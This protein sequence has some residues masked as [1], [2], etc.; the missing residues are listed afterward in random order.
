M[1]DIINVK[2]DFNAVGDGVVDDYPAVQAALNAA[3]GPASQS[4]R[5][6]NVRHNKR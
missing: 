4:K 5:A 3:F 6:S 2:T 1:V